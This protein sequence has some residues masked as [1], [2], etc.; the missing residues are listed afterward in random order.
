MIRIGPEIQCLPYA[1]FFSLVYL[2]SDFFCIFCN[3]GLIIVACRWITLSGCSNVQKV[4]CEIVYIP[5]PL[6]K[7]VPIPV[8]EAV[9]G[10]L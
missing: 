10:G 2:I 8:Y 7:R 5:I 6:I 1:G 3:F 4:H 9:G